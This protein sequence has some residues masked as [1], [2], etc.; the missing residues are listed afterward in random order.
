MHASSSISQEQEPAPPSQMV[1]VAVHA[2]TL[3]KQ[4]TAGLSVAQRAPS[5]FSSQTSARD[6]TAQLSLVSPS[7]HPPHGLWHLFMFV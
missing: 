7:Q 1:E 4:I 6:T 3:C 2:Q 5:E